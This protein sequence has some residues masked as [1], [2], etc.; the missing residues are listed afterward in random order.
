MLQVSL[1]HNPKVITTKPIKM[2]KSHGCLSTD[3]IIFLTEHNYLRETKSECEK[4]Y[5]RRNLNKDK[6]LRNYEIM[7]A[8]QH[9]Q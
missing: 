6:N 9:S 7:I 3:S 4:T 1:F 5:R 2:M 8:M